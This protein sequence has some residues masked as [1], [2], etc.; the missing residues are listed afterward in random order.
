MKLFAFQTDDR[1]WLYIFA[2]DV[3]EAM[4]KVHPVRNRLRFQDLP[5]PVD[6]EAGLFENMCMDR[7]ENVS[8][9]LLVDGVVQCI[10]PPPLR[11]AAK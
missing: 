4:T 6:C 1:G 5:Y 10:T 9:N 11:T 8:S 3:F 2:S 7:Q